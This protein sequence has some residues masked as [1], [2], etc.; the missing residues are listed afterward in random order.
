[1]RTKAAIVFANIFM[2][3]IE[4]Q[5]LQQSKHKPLEWIRYIDDIKHLSM[6]LCNYKRWSPTIHSESKPIP[7]NNQIYGWNIKQ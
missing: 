5:I 7:R 4:T 2:A 6:S 3:E 1:M